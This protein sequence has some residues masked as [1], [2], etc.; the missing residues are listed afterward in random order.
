MARF[1]PLRVGKLLIRY[2]R[3]VVPFIRMI[4]DDY[5]VALIGFL[6]G[7]SEGPWKTDVF[8]K[9]LKAKVGGALGWE[10]T[11]QQF[12]HLPCQLRGNIYGH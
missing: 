11:L 7:D 2:L 6:F 5:M 8:A 9:A 1:P 10:M 4:N 12:R 3:Y